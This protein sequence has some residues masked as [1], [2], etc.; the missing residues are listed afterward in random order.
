MITYTNEKKFT[1]QSVQ[2]LSPSLGWVSRDSP[3]G[4][5]RHCKTCPRCWLLGTAAALPVWHA[6]WKKAK[7]PLLMKS[8]VSGAWMCVAMQL[9]TFSDQV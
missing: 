6:F 9:C 2:G 5:I 1:Q 7:M 4:C 3:A 8:M